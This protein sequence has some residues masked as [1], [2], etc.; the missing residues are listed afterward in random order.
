MRIP[1]P[2]DELT[3]IER[4]HMEQNQR[5]RAAMSSLD[6]CLAKML[7]MGGCE[8]DLAGLNQPCRW[9]SN[10]RAQSKAYPSAPKQV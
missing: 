7:N 1:Q 8:H 4:Y 2:H 10:P 6:R 3:G 9:C 5:E